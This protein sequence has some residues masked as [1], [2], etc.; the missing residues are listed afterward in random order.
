M[1]RPARMAASIASM[2]SGPVPGDEPDPIAAFE[3]EP[4]EGICHAVDARVG[5]PIVE[6]M[7]TPAPGRAG[8]VAYGGA[9]QQVPDMH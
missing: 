7:S 3:P 5:L 9:R 2:S 4:Q 1:T 6:W 8:R